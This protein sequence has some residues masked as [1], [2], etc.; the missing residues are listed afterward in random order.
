MK[1]NMDITVNRLPA[2][3][4]NS[5]KVNSA[6]IE[7]IDRE[8]WQRIKIPDGG[9]G[10][11]RVILHSD[12]PTGMGEEIEKIA[13]LSEGKPEIIYSGD[14]SEKKIL[15]SCEDGKGSFLDMELIADE[16]DRLT[17]WLTADSEAACK[18]RLA[19]RTRIRALKASHVKLVS[20]NLMGRGCDFINDI[21]I[22][23]QSHAHVE[24][25]QLY[26]GGGN[27]WTGCMTTLSGDDSRTD[28]DV[29]YY[30]DGSGRLDMNYAANHFGRR[31]KSR[32]DVKGVLADGAR[33][34]FR[35]T[36]DFKQGASGSKGDE[37]EDVLMLGDE[38]V[39]QTVPLILCAEEDVEGNHGAS[40][41]R[42]DDDIL[43]YLAS[44]GFNSE[45][46]YSLM[47]KARLEAV[48]GSIGD[49]S[50]CKKIQTYIEE[51]TD[52]GKQKLQG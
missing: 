36:I 27:T 40:I 43:F 1:E 18:G 5:L 15:L 10:G 46:A 47:A 34:L 31:T 44:R 12:I 21:G 38:V 6:V 4:W 19:V 13:E 2:L 52:Y 30:C 7:N 16:G 25:V 33:K 11:K 26:L 20:V 23:C 48:C 3:T 41:G 17:V 35:G 9:A 42:P 8:G 14:T 51:V 49:D 37:T 29:G 24:L 32:M 39:N 50:L 28:I 45:E 22:D